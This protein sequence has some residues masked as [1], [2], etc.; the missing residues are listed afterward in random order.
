MASDSI[1][2]LSAKLKIKMAE[3]LH[4]TFVNSHSSFIGFVIPK[5]Y[6]SN[7]S[8]RRMMGLV[9]LPRVLTMTT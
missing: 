2:N 5:G 4:S 3:F 9:D 6:S 7:C 8:N 1:L